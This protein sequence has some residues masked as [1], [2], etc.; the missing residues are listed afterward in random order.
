MGTGSDSSGSGGQGTGGSASLP[1]VKSSGCGTGAP[2]TGSRTIS[3]GEQEGQYIVSIPSDY[4]Q[5]TAYPLGFAFH[6]FGRTDQNCQ[7]GDCINFQNVMGEEAVLI[8]MKSLAEGWEQPEIREENVDFFE[9]VLDSILVE[10]CIDEARVFVAGTSSG[11][12]FT[13]VLAC[14]FGDRLLAA[15]PVAGYLP[16]SEGCVGRVAAVP[17]HGIDDSSFES[18]ETARD[19]YVERN[20]CTEVTVPELST[21]HQEI[22]DSRDA[23]ET[24]HGCVDYQ[25]C[26]EGLPVRW[27]E[28]SEGGYDNTTHGWPTA[29]G[30]MIW[31]FVSQF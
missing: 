30:Q 24:N 5:D 27:C 25:G 31:D 16:E 3:V 22:R 23:D 15:S 11:A 17:I 21:M 18:G 10:A 4:N 26:D 13:N 28:H 2:M 6:G 19:W 14:R 12:H 7:D 9:A 1:E 29:G 8:Y 20:G